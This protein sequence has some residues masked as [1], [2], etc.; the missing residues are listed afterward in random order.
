MIRAGGYLRDHPDAIES[1]ATV[2]VDGDTVIISFAG[3]EGPPVPI[4]RRE[5]LVL[6][7]RL[8]RAI[9]AALQEED[10]R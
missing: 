10:R 4:S 2:D 1:D 8:R 9:L 6:A 7:H 5:G 3:C